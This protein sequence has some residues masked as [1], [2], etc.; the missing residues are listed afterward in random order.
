MGAGLRSGHR[1]AASAG[2][3][4]SS[5]VRRS[6]PRSADRAAVCMPRSAAPGAPTAVH[7]GTSARI[8][9]I[10]VS[11]E[12]DP[13]GVAPEPL[14]AVEA[15]RVRREDVDDEV[16]VVEEN[17]FGSIVAFGVRGFGT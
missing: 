3:S 2:E 7:P 11:I 5:T 9:P 1:G 4:R 15:A 17:P 14:E 10:S 6:D 16:E 12:L 13:L 8:I